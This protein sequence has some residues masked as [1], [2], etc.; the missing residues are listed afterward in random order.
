MQIAD[1]ILEL[2]AQD[3]AWHTIEEIA[4]RTRVSEAEATEVTTFL[5]S[6]TFIQLDKDH[7][8]AKIDERTSRF[9]AEIE[10]EEDRELNELNALH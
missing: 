4:Q 10:N 8:K 3:K 1:R 2:L 5:A 7:K 9:L 6:L